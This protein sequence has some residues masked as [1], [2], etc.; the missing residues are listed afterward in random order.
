MKKL[1]TLAALVVA[2]VFL[3]ATAANAYGD[4][5]GPGAAAPGSTYTYTI[6]DLPTN[7]DVT[8]TV[9][10]PGDATIVGLVTS[11]P[12]TPTGSGPYTTSFNVTFPTA[13]TY[14][15]S[16][17]QP[18]N[19]IDTLS[20]VVAA[21]PSDGLANTG[22]DV[23]PYLWFGGGLVV[24]GAALITVLIVVRRNKVTTPA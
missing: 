7:A 11:T 19:T 3:P 15:L 24:L 20:I 4:V 6:T 13:G 18:E 17:T 10:G 21:V 2:A 22:V 23:T 1:V 14:V 16:A 8:L 12:K 5:S 9:N